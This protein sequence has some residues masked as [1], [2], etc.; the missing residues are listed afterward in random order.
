MQYA[1]C[2]NDF[3]RGASHAPDLYRICFFDE[4]IELFGKDCSK[5]CVVPELRIQN[6]IT[7]RTGVS[8]N[9]D[10]AALGL[11]GDKWR[12]RANQSAAMRYL[13]LFQD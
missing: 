3:W 10:V 4:A 7:T 5:Q 12:G 8:F 6:S 9:A 11:D 13:V 2:P 1:H